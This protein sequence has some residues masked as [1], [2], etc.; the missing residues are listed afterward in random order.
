[1]ARH[2][3][4][5]HQRRGGGIHGGLDS[6]HVRRRQLLRRQDA[7]QRDVEDCGLL[8]RCAWEHKALA[9]KAL[10]QLGSSALMLHCRSRT[11]LKAN[12]QA[13]HGMSLQV[14][15]PSRTKDALHHTWQINK[16]RSVY[17]RWVTDRWGAGPMKRT[18]EGR[19]HAL[20]QVRQ[21]AAA[22]YAA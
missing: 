16:E 14:W 5:P 1:M 18:W 12:R 3:A 7:E 15:D 6:R 21:L 22:V 4:E 11:L 2:E 19:P 8:R 20:T 13:A 9:L 10:I 17:W